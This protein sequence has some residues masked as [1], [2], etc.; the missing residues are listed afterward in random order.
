MLFQMEKYLFKVNNI[1][2]GTISG[3]FVVDFK[4]TFT[5]QELGLVRHLVYLSMTP[6]VKFNSEETIQ[7][8]L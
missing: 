1:N 5:K 3:I 4:E 2:T 7:G 6:D 8:S